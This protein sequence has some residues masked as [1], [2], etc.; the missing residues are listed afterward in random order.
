MN[1]LED[2]RAKK[3]DFENKTK[4]VSELLRVTGGFQESLKNS[5][6]IY[7]NEIKQIEK[8]IEFSRK[9]YNKDCIFRPFILNFIETLQIEI[10]E[11]NNIKRSFLNTPNFKTKLRKNFHFLEKLKKEYSSYLSKELH[12]VRKVETLEKNKQ[13]FQFSNKKLP[14]KHQER[15]DRNNQ[16][17]ENAQKNSEKAMK[18]FNQTFLDSIKERFHFV[19]PY[20]KELIKRKGNL[21]MKMGMIYKQILANYQILDNDDN[22]EEY[23]DKL[24]QSRLEEMGRNTQQSINLSNFNFAQQSLASLRKPGNLVNFSVP[25]RGLKDQSLNSMQLTQQ[26]NKINKNQSEQ[27]REKFLEFNKQQNLSQTVDQN[28]I[29]A[30]E[31]F[32]SNQQP[33]SNM[34]KKPQLNQSNVMKNSLDNIVKRPNQIES[35]GTLQETPYQSK[36]SL[37]QSHNFDQNLKSLTSQDNIPNPSTKEVQQ[38]QTN[39]QIE[40]NNNNFKQNIHPRDFVDDVEQG[41]YNDQFNE[42]DNQ[43]INY[44]YSQNETFQD[45]NHQE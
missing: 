23:K 38:N 27:F 45:Q 42:F 26:L 28:F 43:E 31:M 21:F 32:N 4:I 44:Q 29:Q 24:F 15:L 8:M 35:Q 25:G 6:I 30:K 9:F 2:F 12:Y 1:S 22:F 40:L 13:K 17:L 7:S 20:L 16:K 14:K 33:N 37:I 36:E 5:G 19:N 10:D 11:I 34:F 3:K 39:S 18:S 41:Q